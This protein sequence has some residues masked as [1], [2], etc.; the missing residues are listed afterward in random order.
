MGWII[1]SAVDPAPCGEDSGGR[2]YAG[3]PHAR[4]YIKGLAETGW[5][6][7]QP[8]P[9]VMSSHES[10]YDSEERASYSTGNTTPEHDHTTASKEDHPSTKEDVSRLFVKTDCY[11]RKRPQ[12][13]TKTTAFASIRTTLTHNN[14]NSNHLSTGST[15]SSSSASI[16]SLPESPTT[17]ASTVIVVN[18]QSRIQTPASASASVA[19]S[20]EIGAQF[21]F[22]PPPNPERPTPLFKSH[23]ELVLPTR[24]STIGGGQSTSSRAYKPAQAII[25]S[26]ASV[27][28][29][30]PQEQQSASTPQNDY[31]TNQF[32]YIGMNDEM[33]RYNYSVPSSPTGS[34]YTSPIPRQIKEPK[35]PLYVP[36][37][38]RTKSQVPSVSLF[39]GPSESRPPTRFHWQPDHARKNC[40]QCARPFG[41]F[42]RRHH[43]RKCGDIFCA[44]DSN[45]SV[46]LDHTVSF[47]HLNG[48]LSRA[49]K[50]CA[51]DYS[52]YRDSIFNDHPAAG[53]PNND[54]MNIPQPQQLNT[55]NVQSDL[56]QAASVPKDWSWSTF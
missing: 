5:S 26:P 16:S 56:D 2:P 55:T 24:A 12:R 35:T 7:Q 21:P 11:T 27:S 36:A 3:G 10:S 4:L 41:L 38:L 42:E 19:S 34:G 28:A 30:Q 25:T 48:V 54:I 44:D 39:S 8:A 47:N 9:A 1:S 29:R 32:P 52:Q 43:C 40:T 53:L 45:Y 37:V 15:A 33:R 14:N 17:T 6:P 46:P 31:S 23:S 22:A 18:D 13:P 50:G 51:D 49:C 20:V